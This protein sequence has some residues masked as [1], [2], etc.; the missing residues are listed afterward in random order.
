M[1]K[2]MALAL[3]GLMVLTLSGFVS[4]GYYLAPSHDYGHRYSYG[5]NSYYYPRSYVSYQPYYGHGSSYYPRYYAPFYP[6]YYVPSYS[7]TYYRF[8]YYPSYGYYNWRY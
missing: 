8:N 4:A 5:Y 7:R 1:R 6:R 2:L 3:I